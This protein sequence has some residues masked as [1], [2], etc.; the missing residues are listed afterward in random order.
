MRRLIVSLTLGIIGMSALTQI[1]AESAAVSEN[2][3]PPPTS[4][5]VEAHPNIPWPVQAD[6]KLK[7][8]FGVEHIVIPRGLQ[9]S[10]FCTAHGTLVVQAQVPEKPAPTT[11]IAYFSA[12]ATLISRDG[13]E[14]WARIPLV[15]GQNGLN[16]EG[17]GIQLRDGTI[18]TLDTYITPGPQPD[19]GVGQIYTSND[20]WLT[21]QGPKDVSFDLPNVNF[22]ASA[23]DGG[24]PH[25]AV[26][27]HRRILEEPNG[28]LIT[29]IYGC[30]QGDHTPC[31]YQP[32][33]MKQRMMFARSSD[34]GQ[35]WKMISNVAVSPDVG[36]EGFCE[37][38]I[39]R[40]SQGPH[41]GRI[42]CL[43][44]T[45]RNLYQAISDDDGKTWTPAKEIIIGGIDV[46]RTEM[47]VDQFRNFKD[48]KG[49]L[50]DENNPEE[51][52]GAVV[53]PDMI[54]LRSGLLVAA[55]GVR[56]PQK[57]CWNHPEHPWNGNY[58]AFSTDHGETWS[59][60][61]R[62]TSGVLTTQYMAITETPTDN[63]LFFC[64]DLGGWG[65][66]M[67]RDVIGRTLSITQTAGHAH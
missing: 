9:P 42:I 67:R 2:T 46:N 52:R 54:E 22:Y 25:N 8:T 55:F 59:N 21:V 51:L 58:L 60:V 5:A 7:L 15:S 17:G 1:R 40:V 43:A 49:R 29:T 39:C 16:L 45:G 28:N 41:A 34:K 57:Q 4:V 14:D 33:M 18:L 19:S 26:R 61:V 50:L 3:A 6:G 20:D 53:D 56:I 24:H 47:W 48:S 38:V 10:M 64:Y 31:P 27:A 11:R 66:G 12:M 62:I 23:D 65:K 30:L 35:T 36:T 44:R 32:K 13:G 37:P 63:E